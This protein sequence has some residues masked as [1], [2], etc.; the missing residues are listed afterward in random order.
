MVIF[1]DHKSAIIDRRNTD[2][3]T[4]EIEEFDQRSIT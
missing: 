4:V 1:T 2:P 3:C